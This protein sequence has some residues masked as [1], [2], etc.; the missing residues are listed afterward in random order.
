MLNG[1]SIVHHDKLAVGYDRTVTRYAK[2]EQV[3]SIYIRDIQ[4]L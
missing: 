3:S 4:A 1:L 2:V